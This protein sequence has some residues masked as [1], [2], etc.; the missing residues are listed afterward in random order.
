MNSFLDA[1]GQPLALGMAVSIFLDPRAKTG[2][3]TGT[4]EHLVANKRTY[5]RGGGALL[6]AVVNH[7]HPTG[8]K[9]ALAYCEEAGHPTDGT[10][11][12]RAGP[13]LNSIAIIR[14]DSAGE[15]A[16]VALAAGRPV[17]PDHALDD[18]CGQLGAPV[19]AR[20]CTCPVRAWIRAD[21]VNP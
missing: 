7:L 17:H 19:G 6:G 10:P 20:T 16:L 3:L 9:A 12:P 11:I 4:I 8:R 14:L 15:A 5:P 1:K 21:M 2:R 13:I 18:S